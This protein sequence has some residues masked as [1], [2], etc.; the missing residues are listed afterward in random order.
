[1]PVV[2]DPPKYHLR[3]GDQEFQFLPTVK[4]ENAT[5][6]LRDYAVQIGSTPVVVTRRGRP[7]AVLM[8]VPGLDLE[9]YGHL[10]DSDILTFIEHARRGLVNQNRGSGE[11]PSKRKQMV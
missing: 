5:A 11:R 10:V 2:I 9:A 1:M 8:P 6:S 4:I 7:I 3:I